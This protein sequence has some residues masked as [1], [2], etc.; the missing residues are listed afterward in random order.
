MKT[1]IV[2]DYELGSNLKL[3]GFKLLFFGI[4]FAI[5]R[6]DKDGYYKC[7]Y[8]HGPHAIVCSYC[9]QHIRHTKNWFSCDCGD[10]PDSGIWTEEEENALL[11]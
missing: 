1:F 9:K 11:S 6:P 10:R 3:T 4:G 8:C 5:F 7:N 2:K